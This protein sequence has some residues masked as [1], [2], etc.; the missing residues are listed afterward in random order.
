MKILVLSDI[1]SGTKNLEKLLKKAENRGIDLI[2]VTGDLTNF[3]G[4]KEAKEVIEIIKKLEKKIFAVPGNLD[5]RE[6]IDLLEKK[7]I[8]IHSKKEKFN[9]FIF[10]GFGGA[11]DCI[12]ETVFTETEI[13]EKLKLLM[14]ET[15]NEKVFL[16]THSPPKKSSLDKSFTGKHIGS[17]AVRKIIEEFKPEFSVSGHCHEGIGEEKIKET[18]CV[19]PGSV[20]EKRTVIIDTETKIN[21]VI[22]L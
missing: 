15:E 14:Q 12:G 4:K 5:K 13:Y 11:T 21:E 1:H 7:G 18:F 9:E 16:V 22:E 19:N 10:V 17:A 2:L 8:S 3:G 6:T 20:K